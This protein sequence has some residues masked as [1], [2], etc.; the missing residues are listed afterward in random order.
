[1]IITIAITSECSLC[2]KEWVGALYGF[3]ISYLEQLHEVDDV[4]ILFFDRQQLGGLI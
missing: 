1:M 3:L 4:I 2:D